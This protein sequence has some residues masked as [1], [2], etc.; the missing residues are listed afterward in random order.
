MTPDKGHSNNLVTSSPLQK[1]KFH[2]RRISEPHV[3][4]PH[5]T[6][7]YHS[8]IDRSRDEENIENDEFMD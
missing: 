7:S 1:Y 2:Q 6:G 8:Y 3:Y 5:Y 4:K